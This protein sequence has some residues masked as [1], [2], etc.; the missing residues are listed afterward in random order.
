MDTHAITLRAEALSMLAQGAR[1]YMPAYFLLPLITVAVYWT[2]VTPSLS[3]AWLSASLLVV[4]FRYRL[5]C[6]LGVSPVSQTESRAVRSSLYSGVLWS[7]AVL[8]FF[9]P[10]ASAGQLYLLGTVFGLTSTALILCAW[11]PLTWFAFAA[12]LLGTLFVRFLLEGNTQAC[13]F[14]VLTL[15][16][17]FVVMGVLQKQSALARE[18][19]ELRYENLD[20]L[21]KLRRE[22]ELAENANLAKSK[23]LAAASHDL[24]QPM[25]AIGLFTSALEQ[26]AHKPDALRLINYIR[27]SVGSLD[28]LLSVLLDI[29]RLDAGVITPRNTHCSLN[30]LLQK[31]ANEYELQAREKNLRWYLD[32]ETDIVVYTDEVL[33]ETVIRNLVS[34]AI[35]YTE[36]G[37][38]HVK[39]DV[40]KES[41]QVQ[42]RVLDTGSGISRENQQAIFDEFFQLQTQAG[43]KR[44]GVGL[45]LSIVKR[46]LHVMGY[47]LTLETELHKGSCFSVDVPLG[48]PAFVGANSSMI[49]SNLSGAGK[50]ILVIDEDISILNAM[51]ELLH[52]WSYH[53]VCVSSL[54][55]AIDQVKSRKF[56]PDLVITEYRFAHDKNCLPLL[57]QLQGL[58]KSEFETL[59]ITGETSEQELRKLHASPFQ[60]LHKPLKPAMLRAWLRK[61]G[62]QA[63]VLELVS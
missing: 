32:I 4:W 17:F 31:I 51:E 3:L 2:Q 1:K 18:S 60:V 44:A 53:V 27:D 46:L 9:D 11:L 38:V 13:G 33:L 59:V 47:S 55:A 40:Q 7:L 12:P 58:A 62:K 61:F 42:V 28:N 50:K 30:I 37:S 39:A 43:E 5:V 48:D 16:Y 22:K 24:R 45:G 54:A 21:E 36:I 52:T 29:S 56:I 41:G 34:N 15:L 26:H 19:L 6:E 49:E 35:R 20:L 25:H 23:F 10:T 8:M 14:S 63:P 57:K